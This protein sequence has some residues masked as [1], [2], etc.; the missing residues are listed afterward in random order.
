MTLC[1]TW[2]ISLKLTIVALRG[3]LRST[4]E[5]RCE[6]SGLPTDRLTE[7]LE[8]R[9]RVTE[10][11]GVVVVED[12]QKT[13]LDLVAHHV[14]PA[15][16]LGVDRLPRQ[17]DHVNEQTLGETVLTHHRGR[18]LP[19]LLGELEG[20]VVGDPQQVVPF[21]TGHGLAHGWA[22]LLETLGDPSAERRNALLLQFIDRPEVH[23]GGIDEVLHSTM[24]FLFTYATRTFT[25]AF[26]GLFTQR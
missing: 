14:L 21:H 10:R 8:T 2:T 3:E 24:A 7:L 5:A 23:L 12:R 26:A 6:L 13:R 19:A 9:D 17:P 1:S 22:G 20:P 4:S 18:V 11:R 25:V 15:A 16:C